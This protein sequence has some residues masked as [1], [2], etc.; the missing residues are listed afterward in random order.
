MQNMG[1]DDGAK[2]VRIVL[3]LFSRNHGYIRYFESYPL[4][5]CTDD[6]ILLRNSHTRNCLDLYFSSS[7]LPLFAFFSL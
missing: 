5:I 2:L 7:S 6:D 3:V 4:M 1:C